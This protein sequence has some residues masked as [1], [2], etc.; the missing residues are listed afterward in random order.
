MCPKC[1]DINVFAWP[2]SL[3]VLCSSPPSDGPGFSQELPSSPVFLT[4]RQ[5]GHRDGRGPSI[6]H[7]QVILGFTLWHM[8]SLI[9][10]IL[11]LPHSL[12][13][14]NFQN[15]GKQEGKRLR[16]SVCFLWGSEAPAVRPTVIYNTKTARSLCSHLVPG[17]MLGSRAMNRKAPVSA[18]LGPSSIEKMP[19]M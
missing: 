19:R 1:W 12:S 5:P 9:H 4:E 7:S 6:T 17:T 11:S 13:W 14:G 15:L 16:S 8:S 18:H 3:E 10:Y 2:P